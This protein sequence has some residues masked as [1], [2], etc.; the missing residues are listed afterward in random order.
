LLWLYKNLLALRR[1]HPSLHRGSYRSLDAPDGVFAYERRSEAEVA[2]IALN[3]SDESR[4]V[5][6][7]AG[8]ITH[9]LHTNENTSVATPTDLEL[10]PCGGIVVILAK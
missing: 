3:F 4:R 10:A 6:L 2:R 7:G 1:A 5:S 9:Q 8:R